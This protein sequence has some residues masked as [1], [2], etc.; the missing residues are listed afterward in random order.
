MKIKMLSRLLVVFMA[1]VFA[2]TM[3]F[4]ADKKAQPA[5]AADAKKV[6]KKAEESKPAA[7]ESAKKEQIDI[8]TATKE[9]LMTLP[10]IGEAL[11]KKIIDGRPY[12]MKTELKQKK[13]IPGATYDKISDKIIAKQAK[14]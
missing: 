11:A 9:Q 10:G 1:L 8:N 4:A 12:K 5:P 6:E 2:S 7:A 3:S 13:I 14:K